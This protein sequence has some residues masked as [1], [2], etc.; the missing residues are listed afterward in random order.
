MAAY[1]AGA[2][3]RAGKEFRLFV[4]DEGKWLS[5][6]DKRDLEKSTRPQLVAEIDRLL[7]LEKKLVNLAF[8]QMEKGNNGYVTLQ[9]GTVT[10]VHAG[11]G[12]L[13]V[14][15]DDGKTGQLSEYGTTILRRLTDEECTTMARLVREDYESGDRLREFVSRLSVYQGRKGLEK[16]VKE[17]LEKDGKV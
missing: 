1:P 7:R 3:V 6:F 15:W 17:L 4:N 11:T 8:T 16:Q 10:G 12:N 13:L 5:V 14:S 9:H 2:I